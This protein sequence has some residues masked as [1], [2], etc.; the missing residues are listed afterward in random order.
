MGPVPQPTNGRYRPPQ[1]STNPN[2]R[3]DKVPEKR[4]RVAP[5]KRFRASTAADPKEAAV[6]SPAT[7]TKAP[8]NIKPQAQEGTSENTPP[9]K[10]EEQS[11]TNPKTEKC[12]WGPNCPF[13]KKQEKEEEDWDGNCQNQLQTQP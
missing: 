11:F 7:I 3:K 2:V 10:A 13:C 5:T 4:K 6:H 9:P 1:L 12:G 8:T